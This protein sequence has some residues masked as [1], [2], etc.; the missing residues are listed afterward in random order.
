MHRTMSNGASATSIGLVYQRGLLILCIRFPTYSR[1]HVQCS[2]SHL[3][4]RVKTSGLG[5]GLVSATSPSFDVSTQES[6]AV[7]RVDGRHNLHRMVGHRPG[8]ILCALWNLIRVAVHE[9]AP[10][11]V[12]THA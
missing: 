10:S 7:G 11:R 3:G 4:P 5:L 1:H 8:M 12:R 6:S 2:V 9:R